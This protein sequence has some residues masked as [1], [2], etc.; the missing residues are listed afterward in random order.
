MTDQG[1]SAE[2]IDTSR[3]HPARMYDYYLGGRDNYQ[4]DR[5]AAER[6]VAEIPEIHAAAR[7]NRAFL[8]RAVRFVVERGMRQIIDIGTGIP[9]SPNPHEIA[10][11]IAPDVRVAYIDND[12]IVASHAGARLV[13]TPDT[14]FALADVRKPESILEHPT[15]REL[16]DFDRPVAVLLAAV[17]HFVTDEEAPAR[18]VATL[19]E[20]LPAGSHLVLSHVTTDCHP[21]GI[22]GVLEVYENATATLNP[23]SHAEILPFFEGFRVLEPGLVQVPLWRPDSSPPPAGALSGIG[24]YGGVAVKD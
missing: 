1:F 8:E 2:E 5:E 21:G 24:F 4:V 10:R 19:S 15:V 3:P 6:V 17:L 7:M 23:R 11:E 16:I 13:G 20:A 9:T 18:V 12:P 22:P 14:G